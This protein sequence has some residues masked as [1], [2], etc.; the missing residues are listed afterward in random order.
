MVPVCLHWNEAVPSAASNQR[1]RCRS[2]L[3]PGCIE[4]TI[5]SCCLHRFTWCP[6][7]EAFTP[8]PSCIQPAWMARRQ[9]L[10]L[11]GRKCQGLFCLQERERKSSYPCAATCTA[12]AARMTTDAASLAL[13]D[14]GVGIP[15]FQREVVGR[16]QMLSHRRQKPR[17][18]RDVGRMRKVHTSH[19][20]ILQVLHT[21]TVLDSASG[22]R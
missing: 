17:G 9:G 11:F 22:P 13:L 15:E 12:P 2:L 16:W 4:R 19:S 6:A 21:P 14:Q 18:S 7:T 8:S 1:T 3:F 10:L 5:C 20:A